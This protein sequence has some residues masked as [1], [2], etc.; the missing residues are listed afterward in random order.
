MVVT[1]PS[2]TSDIEL[3]RVEGVPGPATCTCYSPDRGSPAR[4]RISREKARDFMIVASSGQIAPVS[5]HDHE[6]TRAAGRILERLM[7]LRSRRTLVTDGTRGRATL[8]TWMAHSYC[9]RHGRDIHALPA[10][11][12]HVSRT[13]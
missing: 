5:G 2:A 7:S 6:V 1:S 10:R 13:T 3:I 12:G 11:G 8:K 4:R 9:E